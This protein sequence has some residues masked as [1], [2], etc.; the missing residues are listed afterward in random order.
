MTLEDL[1]AQL[2]ELIA[3]TGSLRAALECAEACPSESDFD[4]N[5]TDAIE[6]VDEIE[7]RCRRLRKGVRG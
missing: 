3:H 1:Q 7:R 4:S 2:P 5:L 6:I